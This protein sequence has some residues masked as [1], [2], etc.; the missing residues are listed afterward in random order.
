MTQGYTPKQSNSE[1]T[2]LN[3]VLQTFN[4][5]ESLLPTQYLGANVS[6]LD[7]LFAGLL[8]HEEWGK[9]KMCKFL[10]YTAKPIPN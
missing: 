7:H 2:I 6:A 10:L 9:H 3:S 4:E 5:A 1:P 8:L